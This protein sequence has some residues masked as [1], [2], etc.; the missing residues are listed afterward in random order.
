MNPRTFGE[1]PSALTTEYT[2]KASSSP[3][4]H[5]PSWPGLGSL[6]FTDSSP[7]PRWPVIVS[8]MKLWLLC[9]GDKTRTE[10]EE[11]SEK[12]DMTKDMEFLGITD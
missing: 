8:F 10:N 3:F 2:D 7:R 12:E 6:P 4:D 5:V 11:F 1:W 9:L